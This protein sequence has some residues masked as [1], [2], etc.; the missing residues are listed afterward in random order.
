MSGGWETEKESAPLLPMF[1]AAGHSDLDD[2]VSAALGDR[3]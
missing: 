2:L 1:R 3:G